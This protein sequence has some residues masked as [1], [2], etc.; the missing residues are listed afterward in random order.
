MNSPSFYIACSLIALGVLTGF[1]I[2][3]RFTR[4]SVFRRLYLSFPG[5]ILAFVVYGLLAF[6]DLGNGLSEGAHRPAEE[7]RADLGWC[8]NAIE[9]LDSG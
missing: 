5:V 3:A 1:A 7:L 6:G 2:L 4:I 9:T 8:R